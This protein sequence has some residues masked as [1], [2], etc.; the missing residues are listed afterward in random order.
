MR[1]T[2][3]L[4]AGLLIFGCAEKPTEVRTPAELLV[5]GWEAYEAGD[6]EKA[7]DLF[8]RAVEGDPYLEEAYC[9]MGWAYAKLDRLSEAEDALKEY[10][11][12]DAKAGLAFV[13]NALK[14][15]EE[16]I[17]MARDVLEESPTWHFVHGDADYRTLRL[18]IAQDLYA[19][20][21]F[22]ES[23]AE[24]RLLDGSFSA[25]VSTPEGRASLASKIERL[26]GEI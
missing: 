3:L 1:A 24:V 23:L 12:T 20:A 4:F 25:D 22:E 2:S 15:Y 6:Y 7:L 26:K 10:Q 16:S 17:A 21:R 18:L 8:A 14:R 9:G 13:Y 5:D 11:T 19:L